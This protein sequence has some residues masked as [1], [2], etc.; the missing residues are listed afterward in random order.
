MFE[1]T[2][3]SMCEVGKIRVDVTSE[4]C[5]VADPSCHHVVEV[6]LSCYLLWGAPV[7]T[8]LRNPLSVTPIG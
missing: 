5:E 4:S 7:V 8:S 6:F 3:S 1:T 2:V